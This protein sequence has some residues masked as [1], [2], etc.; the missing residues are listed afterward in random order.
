MKLGMI[1]DNTR[2]RADKL[3][4]QRRTDLDTLGIRWPA[5]TAARRT[6]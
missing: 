6:Q 5:T 4:S 3:T 2:K 1:L